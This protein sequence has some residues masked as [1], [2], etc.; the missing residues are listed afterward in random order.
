VF[1]GA[2]WL[3][4]LFTVVVPRGSTHGVHCRSS[5]GS[6]PGTSHSSGSRVL[7][8]SRAW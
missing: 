3:T 7:R 1:A 5:M 4:Q 6:T 2:A 8:I